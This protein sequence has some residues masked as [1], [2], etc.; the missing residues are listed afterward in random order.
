MAPLRSVTTRATRST[1]KAS[2]P[3]P[4]PYVT[5]HLNNSRF[6]SGTH[7]HNACR[8]TE[9]DWAKYPRFED[10]EERWK[11]TIDELHRLKN[12]AKL[13][14]LKNFKFD[15]ATFSMGR[16]EA[17]CDKLGID[18]SIFDLHMCITNDGKK[19]CNSTNWSWSLEFIQN[20]VDL[21]LLRMPLRRA[22]HRTTIVQPW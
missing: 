14:S 1:S 7:V 4:S 15:Q 16:I 8:A 2:S 5:S 3:R 6:M 10:L 12:S 17:A 18:G 21:L 9:E 19:V 13:A 11:K 22:R 20:V